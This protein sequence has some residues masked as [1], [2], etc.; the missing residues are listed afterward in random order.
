MN[1]EKL[2]VLQL[3]LRSRKFWLALFAVIQTIVFHYFDVPKDVWMS[4]DALVGVL[5][6]AIAVEDF[7]EKRNVL[8]PNH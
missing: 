3:L 7:A 6:S 1:G 5:I 4:V 2:N 8:P